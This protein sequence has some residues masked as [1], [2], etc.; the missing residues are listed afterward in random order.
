MIT[1]I[2]NNSIPNRM[3]VIVNINGED[4]SKI[5]TLIS[6]GK[7]VSVPEFISIAIQNQLSYEEEPSEISTLE[8]II[9]QKL[10]QVVTVKNPVIQ[11]EIK[12]SQ[13]INIKSIKTVLPNQTDQN[14]PFWGTQN[15]YLCLKQITV[16]FAQL[17][18]QEQSQWIRYDVAINSLFK[19]AMNAKERL[20]YIDTT[21]HRPRG[22]RLAIGFPKGDSKSLMRYQRQ[23]IGGIDSKNKVY[24]MA[25][26][27]GFLGL[28]RNEDTNRIE[29]GI[30]E[31]GLKFSLYKS[32]VYDKSADEITPTTK[33]LS[34]EEVAF[35]LTVLRNRLPAEVKFMEF[36]LNYIKDGKNKPEDGRIPTKKY[37]DISYSEIAHTKEGESFSDQESETL[38]AGVISRMNELGLIKINRKG[39]A[40]DYQLTEAGHKVLGKKD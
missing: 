36:T 3:K 39:I 35:I 6:T 27:M 17:I 28:R 31:D 38:R 21:L 23:F 29:F 5:N 8:S 16:D 26:F 33:Q 4:I 32:P 10:K 25:T 18:A 15:K 14:F 19:G 11:T 30:T 22:Y 37:L 24:G 2:N 7:I 20:E 12:P 13:P 34:E 9:D 1:L 40:S